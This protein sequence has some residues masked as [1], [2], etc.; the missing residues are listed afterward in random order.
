MYIGKASEQVCCTCNHWKGTRV[1]GADGFVYSMKKLEGI[2]HGINRW[3]E[4]GEFA[5]AL[6]L[7]GNRCKAWE[8]WQEI[9]RG[10]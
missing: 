1:L 5:L 10:E 4:G 3:E 7:P 9:G 6:T 8:K 2:C